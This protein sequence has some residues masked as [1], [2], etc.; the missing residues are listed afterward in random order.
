MARSAHRGVIVVP[1]PDAHSLV[2]PWRGPRALDAHVTLVAPFAVAEATLDQLG[3][4]LASGLRGEPAF[5]VTFRTVGWFGHRVVFAAPDD[6]RPFEHLARVLEAAIIHHATAGVPTP[7]VPH[8]TI[9][10]HR[11]PDELARAAGVAAGEL[12]LA[13]RAREVDLFVRNTSADSW[14][15]HARCQLGSRPGD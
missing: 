13:A 15:L 2:A 4:R 1:I 5:E 3:E 9:A 8:M 10:A 11:R 7:F 6:A 12:P 14:R